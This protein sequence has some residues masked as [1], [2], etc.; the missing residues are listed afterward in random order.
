M[1]KKGF[2]LIELLVVISIVGVLSSTVFTNV[3]GARYKAHGAYL[4]RTTQAIEK[5][6]IFKGL[7][8]NVF[9]WW[10]ITDFPGESEWDEVIDVGKL[11][12]EGAINEFLPVLPDG[13]PVSSADGFG[14]AP[15]GFTYAY[16][17]YFP[18]SARYSDPASGFCDDEDYTHTVSN[19]YSIQNGISLIIRPDYD[20]QTEKFQKT[21][22]YLDDAIDNGDG[23]NCGKFRVITYPNWLAMYIYTLS[24]STK[25]SH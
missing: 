12:E 15:Y 7:D 2:T 10:D 19:F 1:K 3:F 11:I 21:F 13:I 24:P 14:A 20:F 6:F 25:F 17:N 16:Q 23:Q 8:E 22:K 9:T 5:A 18:T 4:L